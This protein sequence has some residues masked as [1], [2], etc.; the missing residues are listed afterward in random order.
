MGGLSIANPTKAPKGD[1]K[2]H[3]DLATIGSDAAASPV[4]LYREAKFRGPSVEHTRDTSPPSDNA[5]DP[6][7]SPIPRILTSRDELLG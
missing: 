1:A 3:Y 6:H 4:L 2:T 7:Q 5:L